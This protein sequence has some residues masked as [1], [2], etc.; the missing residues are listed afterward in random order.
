[1]RVAL[2]NA[3]TAIGLGPIYYGAS[4]NTLFN[5]SGVPNNPPPVASSAKAAIRILPTSW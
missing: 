2:E 1:M 5:P 3:G 4:I